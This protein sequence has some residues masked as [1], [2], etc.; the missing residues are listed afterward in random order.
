MFVRQ[1]GLSVDKRSRSPQLL[2]KSRH[3]LE[4]LMI[5]E[6]KAFYFI[7][8]VH[9]GGVIAAAKHHADLGE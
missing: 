5:G 8:G 4:D 3:S 7:D 1:A 6:Q 9:D 2:G